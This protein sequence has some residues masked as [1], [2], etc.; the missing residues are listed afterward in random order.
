M[1]KNCK[2]KKGVAIIMVLIIIVIAAPV[3]MMVLNFSTSQKKESLHFNTILNLEQVSLSGINYAYSK[4]KGNER[5]IGLVPYPYPGE[6]SGEDRFD[7]CIQNTG[8]GFFN[9]DNYLMLSKT[10][11]DNNSSIIIA[12]SEQFVPGMDGD[13]LVITK[14]YWTTPEPFQI[15]EVSDVLSMK[16]TRGKDQIRA[17]EIKEL[18]LNSDH[19]SFLANIESLRNSLPKPIAEVWEDVAKNITRE[20]A[21]NNEA[22]ASERK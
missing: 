15:S 17:L 22:E 1:N 19:K 16:N 3:V 14:D 6:V 11:K 10:V 20:K 5:P 8:K 18:E 4:L 7:L 12:D 13:I 9:Q 2:N 21:C